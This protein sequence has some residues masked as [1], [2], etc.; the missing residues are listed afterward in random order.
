VF[1][2]SR[3]SGETEHSTTGVLGRSD[4]QDVRRRRGTIQVV[5]GIV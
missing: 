2:K 3:E 4:P 1:P 5:R